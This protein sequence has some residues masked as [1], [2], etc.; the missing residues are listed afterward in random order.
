[1]LRVSVRKMATIGLSFVA[2]AGCGREAKQ[3]APVQT[4]AGGTLAAAPAAQAAAQRDTALVRVLHAIPGGTVADVFAGDA[5]AFNQLG[6]RSLTPYRELPAERTT[7]R[8]RPAGQDRAEP[9][10]EEAEGLGAGKHYTV[11]IFPGEK[12]QPATMRVISDDLVPPPEGKARVRLV[13]ASPD[14]GKI[15]V[16][17]GGRTSALVKGVSADSASD[18]ADTEPVQGTL[19]VRHDDKVLAN[20][21][22]TS[23][24]PGT[25][26]TVFLMGRMAERRGVE[27]MV[28]ADRV[29]PPAD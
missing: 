6:Y 29:E 21:P 20:V 3:T 16:F 15:D 9:L 13:N 26:Y 12:D 4:E 19:E 11:V 23:I 24:E 18:Y 8:L 10:A 22:N 1:V 17:V 7:F 2:L 5:V 28:T 14:V 25:L 27:A